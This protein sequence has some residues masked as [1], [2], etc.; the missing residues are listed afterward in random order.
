MKK[1]NI[2]K[3]LNCYLLRTLGTD[4]GMIPMVS[5]NLIKIW[6]FLLQQSWQ[7]FPIRMSSRLPPSRKNLEFTNS[8]ISK[9]E[10]RG[11]RERERNEI[12]RHLQIFRQL[13][14]LLY[15]SP[16]ITFWVNKFLFTI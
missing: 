11:G 14:S 7:R 15:R 12:R 1:R 2:A 16:S 9:P 3:L 5:S 4:I 10:K 13:L 8:W 6:S